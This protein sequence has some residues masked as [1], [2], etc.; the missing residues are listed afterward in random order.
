MATRLLSLKKL[1]DYR[2]HIGRYIAKSKKIVLA[3]H[4]TFNSESKRDDGYLHKMEPSMV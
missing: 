3:K 2:I 4:K 1:Q